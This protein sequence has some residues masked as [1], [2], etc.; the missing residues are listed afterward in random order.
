MTEEQGRKEGMKRVHKFDGRGRVESRERLLNGRVRR[1]SC[2]R[3]GRKGC[4]MCSDMAG[5]QEGEKR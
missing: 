4:K 3:E 5:E 2:D 1:Q